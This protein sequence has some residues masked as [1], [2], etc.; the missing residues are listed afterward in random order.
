MSEDT[1]AYGLDI[2]TNIVELCN[3][4]LLLFKSKNRYDAMLRLGNSNPPYMLNQLE[5]IKDILNHPQ[6]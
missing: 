6:C 3:R 4:I 2:N 5:G 1:G